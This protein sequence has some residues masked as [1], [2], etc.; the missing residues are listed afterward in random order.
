MKTIFRLVGIGVAAVGLALGGGFTAQAGEQA[1]GTVKVPYESSG[2]V[3][4]SANLNGPNAPTVFC[5]TLL[6]SHPYVPALEVAQTCKTITAGTVTTRFD[7][8]GCGKYATL[9]TAKVNG[10]TTFYK[11]SSFVAICG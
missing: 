1:S 3:I 5:V 9:A 10:T 7:H 6:A 2:V 8:S 11:Q 4:G